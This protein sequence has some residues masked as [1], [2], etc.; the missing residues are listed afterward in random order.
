MLHESSVDAVLEAKLGCVQQRQTF[1]KQDM[2][3]SNCAVR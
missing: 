3:T 2:R 1:R